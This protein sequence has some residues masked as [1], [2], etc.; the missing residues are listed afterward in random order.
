M[1]RVWL[2][3]A[4][5]GTSGAGEQF[6]IAGGRRLG[7]VIDPRTGSPA[8]GMLSA[9]VVC[10]SAA[11]ADALSTAFLIGGPELAARYC[12]QHPGVLALLTPDGD[13]EATIVIGRCAGV[14]VE[15]R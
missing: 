3:D 1:A 13:S 10:G 5:L 14:E 15:R 12:R 2:R 4:A 6:V 11:D 7:H 9:T 8:E